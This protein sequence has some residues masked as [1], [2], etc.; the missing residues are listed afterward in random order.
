ME[1]RKQDGCEVLENE[2]GA[3]VHVV[4]WAMSP[5]EFKRKAGLVLGKLHLFVASVEDLEPYDERLKQ[6]G[7]MEDDEITEI[8]SRAEGNPDAI[9]YGTFYS[10]EKDDS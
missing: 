6:E 5:F 4:T 7:P 8:V 3:F 10:Y 1:V 2:K 9:I